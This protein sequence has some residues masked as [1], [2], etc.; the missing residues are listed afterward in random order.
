MDETGNLHR[1]II[2]LTVG[3]AI[4]ESQS[5][6]VVVDS[7]I[8]R[9]YQAQPGRQEWITVVECIC[10]D[11]STIRPRIIFKGK[12]LMQC[13]ESSTVYVATTVSSDYGRLR[14]FYRPTSIYLVCR[15]TDFGLQTTSTVVVSE[16]RN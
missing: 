14:K 16:G 7:T 4:G 6:Y 11:G 9:K 2:S 5:S 3:F 15:R 8:R 1:L 10:A 12:S 13:S